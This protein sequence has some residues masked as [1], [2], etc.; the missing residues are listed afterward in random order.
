[1]NYEPASY[2]H[3]NSIEVVGVMRCPVN[4]NVWL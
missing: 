3:A 4:E 2:E 1:M